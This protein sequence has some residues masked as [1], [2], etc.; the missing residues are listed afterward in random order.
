MKTQLRNALIAVSLLLMPTMN[1]AQTPPLGTAAGFVLFTTVGAVGI[2]GVAQITGNVGSNNGGVTISVN[3]N[4]VIGP[5]AQCAADLLTAYNFLNSAVPNFFPAPLLGNGQTLDAGVYSISGASTLN[6]NLI[7]DAQSNG[8]AVFIF[9]I[10]GPFS[11]NAN[12][13]IILINGAMACNVFWKVEGLVSMASGTTMRGTIIAN[14]AAINI[15]T[16]DTLEGRALS[17]TGAVNFHGVMAY[18]PIGCGSPVLTGP[19]APALLTTQCYA[20]F[21]TNGPVSNAGVTNITGDVGTNVGLTTGF[22]PLFVTGTIHPIPD[23]STAQCAADLGTVYTYLN[24]LPNDIQLMY[25]AQFGNN[26][27]LTPHTYLMNAAT[28]FTDTLYLN[29]EGD[30][31]AVFVIK[32]N[33]ALST[34][35]YSKVILTNGTLA[36]NVY[37]LVNGAVSIMDYSVFKGTI[38]CNNGAILLSTG[39]ALE[40]RALTTTGALG[41]TAITATMPPGCGGTSGPAIITQPVNQTACVGS[42]VSFSVT[43][44]GTGLTYQWRKGN[45]N[46]INGGTI[47][48]ATSATLTINPVNTS[49]AATNYNVVV[50]GTFLPNV[51]SINTS[52]VVNSQPVPTITGQTSL[53]INS[54]NYNYSTETGMTN[55]AWT[56]SSG[57]VINYGSGTNQIQVSWIITGP[58]TVS[59]TYINGAGCNPITPTVMNVTVNPMPDPAGTITGASNVCAGTNGVTYSVTPIPNATTY[60]WALPPDAAIV[61]GAGMNSI[62]VDFG[63]NA[64][65]GNIIVYGNNICGNGPNSPAFTVTVSQQPGLAGTITGPSMVCQGTTGSVYSVNL[66]MNATGYA[67]TV[68]T[69]ATITGG[70]NTNSITVDFSTNAVS[71]NITVC[72]TNSCGSGIVS[73]NFAVTVN[74]IPPA[75]MITNTGTILL[76]NE[77]TGNQWYF[78]GTLITSATDQTYVATQYGHYWDVVTINNCSSSESNHLLIL[79]TG[80]DSHSSPVID[81]YP[82]P[83]EGM[84]TLMITT[85]EEGNYDIRVFNN[86]GMQIFEMK[87][88]DVTGMTHQTIDLSSAASGIYTLVTQSNNFYSVKKVVINK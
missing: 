20:L 81:V 34:S 7:L 59:V 43:A 8:S 52:L 82:N 56:V 16:G 21:S 73:P 19:A 63:T 87:N 39:V 31:N 17:T 9:K 3:V 14:N 67:W 41:T 12:S 25:P 35:T 30:A 2:D 76:S 33:G 44:T 61:S 5:S 32:I 22:N 80:I 88:I 42:S 49:D 62:T 85:P 68:P 46:L 4:G 37:W 75:P 11:T 53:C 1:F 6:G 23:A 15:L 18:T 84:F 78:E 24:A 48:G 40:G 83:N 45:S 10:Q 60:V 72:G 50:T 36:T 54:G 74:V 55:Y 70:A 51:T 57:G 26:L 71:G 28:T 66:I 27:V 79:V 58:Q 29:A 64:T 38:V 77:A 65:F 69:G 86:L 47:S 13:K